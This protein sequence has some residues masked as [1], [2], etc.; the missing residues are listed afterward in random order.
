MSI[1]TGAITNS[2]RISDTPITTSPDGAS[3]A[4]IALRKSESTTDSLTKLVSIRMTSGTSAAAATSSA[5]PIVALGLLGRR[6]RLLAP[7]Q[8]TAHELGKRLA[9]HHARAD[10]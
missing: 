8:R 3:V 7:L 9:R 10:L 5:L 4:P 2:V 6:C 1:A